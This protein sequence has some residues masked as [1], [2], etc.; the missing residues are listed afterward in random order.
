M[1]H[2]AAMTKSGRRCFNSSRAGSAFC[3][4]H[5]DQVSTGELLAAA[6]GAVVGTALSPG[7]GTVA[8]GLVGRQLRQWLVDTEKRKVRVFLSFDFDNDRSLR[9]LMLGQARHPEAPFEVVN[10]SL[11]EA[12]PEPLWESKATVAIN[13][14][15]L[16][17]VL[18]GRKT[19][20]AQGVLKEVQMAR[21]A[22]VP[23]VQ[24]IGYR[25]R[26]YS[27]VPGAGRVYAWSK[28]NL[29]KLFS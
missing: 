4:A 23:I 8:G 15:D 25:H 9:D 17:V 1:R 7:L 10:Q 22:G 16:V 18:L 21:T 14:A 2:C 29:I 5:A 11:M 27:P 3:A 28:P 6:A 19:S 12:A 20:R 24:I 13:R 26:E